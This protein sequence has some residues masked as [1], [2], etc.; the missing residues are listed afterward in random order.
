MG[1]ARAHLRKLA[2]LKKMSDEQYLA[3]GKPGG[4]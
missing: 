1:L 2:Q 3:R 4:V